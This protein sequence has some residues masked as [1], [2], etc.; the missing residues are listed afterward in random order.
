MTGLYLIPI[1]TISEYNFKKTICNEN[2]KMSNIIKND[3]YQEVVEMMS[4]DESTEKQPQHLGIWAFQENRW[5]EKEE[6][7]EERANNHRNYWE[8]MATNDIVLFFDP[9][10]KLCVFGRIHR[11]AQEE[12]S[13]KLAKLIFKDPRLTFMFSLKDLT[14]F[15]KTT[16]NFDNIKDIV[17]Y[18]E[19]YQLSTL[20]V[21]N[22]R[23]KDYGVVNKLY[24]LILLETQGEKPIG[25]K[26]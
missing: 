10:G 16:I 22:W 4:F 19:N 1:S 26:R 23:V 21:A 17:H 3:E 14:K 2:N 18:V 25:V 20:R 8:N 15:K 9:K 7:E 13:G 6:T 12:V 5:N 11:K 24:E